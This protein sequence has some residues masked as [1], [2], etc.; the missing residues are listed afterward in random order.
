LVTF[1]DVIS[2]FAVASLFAWLGYGPL[3][4]EKNA[5]KGLGTLTDYFMFSFWFYGISAV[6]DYAGQYVKGTTHS[7]MDILIAVPFILGTETLLVATYYVRQFGKTLFK[8]T[9]MPAF[10]FVMEITYLQTLSVLS[11][12]AGFLTSLTYVGRS[13][14]VF[15]AIVSWYGAYRYAKS[16][17][18]PERKYLSWMTVTVLVT[19]LWLVVSEVMFVLFGWPF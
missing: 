15:W 2:F 6:V 16:W 10:S 5:S 7:W 18:K 13:N 4:S 14:F 12:I 3:L 11:T 1:F 17:R 19:F 9:D 8:V